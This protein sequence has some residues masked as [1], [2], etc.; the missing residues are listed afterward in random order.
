MM[1]WRMI[2]DCLGFVTLYENDNESDCSVLMVMIVVRLY[3]M[4][5]LFEYTG[6]TGVN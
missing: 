5:N 4:M 1:I 2:D 3:G 6:S